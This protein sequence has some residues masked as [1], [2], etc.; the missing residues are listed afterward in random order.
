MPWGASEASISPDDDVFRH[1]SL[2]YSKNHFQMSKGQP[3]S[4]D[5]KGFQDGITNGAE[6][7]PLTGGMQDYNYAYYGCLELTLELAC[8]KYPRSNELRKHW[9]MNRNV[10]I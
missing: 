7:Y 10:S 4:P 8:C 1:L 9:D 6:W 5:D 2:V 3:C